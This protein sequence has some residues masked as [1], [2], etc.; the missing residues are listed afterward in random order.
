LLVQ[1]IKAVDYDGGK[2]LKIEAA[3]P[4]FSLQFIG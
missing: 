4:Y 3:D 2:W 1:H